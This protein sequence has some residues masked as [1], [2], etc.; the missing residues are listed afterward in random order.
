MLS[1]IDPNRCSVCTEIVAVTNINMKLRSYPSRIHRGLLSSVFRRIVPLGGH[2]PIVSFTFDDFPRSAYTVG[3]EILERYGCRG[4]YY[5]AID[6]MNS[7]NALGEH[8]DQFDL[9]SLIEKGHEL[10]SHTKSHLSCREVSLKEFHENVQRGRQ[11]IAHV[12]GMMDSGNFAY[13]FGHVTFRAKK[14]LGLELSSCRVNHEGTN[15]PDIDLNM[16]RAN[17]LY[18][19]SDQVEKAQKLILRNQQQKT[20]LIFYSHDV[21]ERPSYWGC[22]PRLLEAAVSYALHQG[23]RIM[24]IASVLAEMEVQPPG[25]TA[26]CNQLES[27]GSTTGNFL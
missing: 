8:F 16:L 27:Q 19:S 13:P 20:W 22:T 9:R 25:W 7:K 3:G 1:E 18:G 21:S 26:S 5:A 10:A 2:G 14:K 15:G 11:A 6:L 4:T 17:S 23:A 12:A 24:T